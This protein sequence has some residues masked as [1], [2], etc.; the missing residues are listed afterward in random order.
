[1][2]KTVECGFCGGIAKLKCSDMKLKQG[3]IV[4]KDI[5][6]YKCSKCGEVFSTSEQMHIIEEKINT[7]PFH[8]PIINAGRSLAI[9]LPADI[10]REYSL[11]KGREVRIIPESRKR[12]IIQL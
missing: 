7:F 1:M 3:T 8:R 12:L 4:I 6:E 5:P 2:Q 11:E 9:T 10:V